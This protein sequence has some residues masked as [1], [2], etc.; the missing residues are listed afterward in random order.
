MA[1][2]LL[3]KDKK[4]DLKYGEEAQPKKFSSFDN[5]EFRKAVAD[6]SERHYVP[7]DHIDVVDGHAAW[8][9]IMNGQGSTRL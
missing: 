9:S 3:F 1:I 5:P 2:S 4:I 8:A 6:N 7:A